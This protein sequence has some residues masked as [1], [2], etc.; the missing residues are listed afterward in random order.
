MAPE[1][2]VTGSGLWTCHGGSVEILFSKALSGHASARLEHIPG[3]ADPV[4]VCRAPDPP[5]YA[6][7]PQSRRMDRVVALALAAAETAWHSAGFSELPPARVAVVVG[8]SRGPFGKSSEP[9]PLRVRPTQATHTAVASVSGALSLALGAQGPCFT[10]SA[11]CAS[12]AHAIALATHLV[13]AGVVDAA[14]A[15][16][17]EAPLVP[18]LLAQFEASGILGHHRDPSLACRPFDGARNGTVP[19]EGAAFLALESARSAH[20]RARPGLAR[21]A[22]AAMGSECHSRAG[23]RAD[24]AGLSRVLQ[25]ALDDA[26]LK[27]GDLGYLN[28]HGTGT[29][30]NDA[31]EAAALHH[32]LGTHAAD[33][34]ISS[35]KAVTGHTFGAAAAIEAV[36]ALEC[37]RRGVVPPTAGCLEVDPDLLRDPPLRWVIRSSEVL[38]RPWVASTSLGF[39]GNTAALILGTLP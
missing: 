39:W 23:T 8:T 28:A 4:P 9:A 3:L 16:G 31:A 1:V 38:P 36:I 13:R 5:P 35:T 22:A 18:G 7:L 32:V 29:R 33:V 26:G 34:P 19:G 20:R 27:A 30:M 11:T 10:V 37:L 2:L 21:I 15:G 14:L 24:G 12:G 17:A 6:A 25:Q